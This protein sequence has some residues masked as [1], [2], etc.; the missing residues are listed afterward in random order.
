MMND[1]IP[2]EVEERQKLL[3]REFCNR[4]PLITSRNRF[5]RILTVILM[6]E[7]TDEL[8]FT[9]GFYR[10]FQEGIKR[11]SKSSGEEPK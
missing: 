1:E 3:W 10:G 8:S 7:T 11:Q 6:K 9:N 2:H 4:Y 5:V